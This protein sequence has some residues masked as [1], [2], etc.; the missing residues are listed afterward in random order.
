MENHYNLKNYRLENKK[1]GV[2]MP[3]EKKAKFYEKS[4]EERETIDNMKL[5]QYVKDNYGNDSDLHKAIK[6]TYQEA[7]NLVKS[8]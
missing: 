8:N 5:E 6:K 7:S 1:L 3:G 2:A 4:F